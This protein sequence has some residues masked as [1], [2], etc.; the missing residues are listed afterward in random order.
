MSFLWIEEASSEEI[1]QQVSWPKDVS[2]L[3]HLKPSERSHS[4]PHGGGSWNS[5]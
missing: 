4:S 1:N 5:M 2:L 3:W